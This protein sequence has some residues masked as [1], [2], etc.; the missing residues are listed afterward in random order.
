MV[1]VCILSTFTTIERERDD[2][3]STI[4]VHSDHSDHDGHNDANKVHAM[5]YDDED[6]E[7]HDDGE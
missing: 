4:R 5:E 2:A 6:D 3:L 7:L 1:C